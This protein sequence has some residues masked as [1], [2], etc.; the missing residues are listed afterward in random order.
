MQL[1]TSS[2]F[3]IFLASASYLSLPETRI[4]QI[5]Q[6]RQ[7]ATQLLGSAKDGAKR[8]YFLPRSFSLL[9][10]A[11]ATFS[12]TGQRL[13]VAPACQFHIQA[14]CTLFVGMM[15]R[16]HNFKPVALSPKCLPGR[17]L[18]DSPYQLAT[19]RVHLLHPHELQ[20][21]Q[22]LSAANLAKREKRPRLFGKLCRRHPRP[23][24]SPADQPSHY[25]FSSY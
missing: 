20:P 23:M 16:H 17:H 14:H 22:Y 21:R 11:F 25:P 2:S 24:C 12:V 15:G 8:R 13:R 9:C 18:L 6:V 7:R 10:P 5:R 19:C 1:L 3:E 4:V